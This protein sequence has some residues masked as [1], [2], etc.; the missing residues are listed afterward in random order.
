MN[1]AEQK[2]VRKLHAYAAALGWVPVYFNDGE[3]KQYG[4]DRERMT[5]DELVASVE[6]VDDGLIIWR[7]YSRKG[8]RGVLTARATIRTIPD[9]CRDGL[10]LFNNW[11]EVD[12]FGQLMADFVIAW[13][14]GAWA[15]VE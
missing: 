2:A 4:A 15:G 9:N 14:S 6:S 1:A 11:S 12:G 7:N 8:D 10:E 5:A 13:E 3:A